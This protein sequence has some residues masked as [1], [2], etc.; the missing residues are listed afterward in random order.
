MELPLQELPC[1]T[2]VTKTSPAQGSTSTVPA[3]Y[4]AALQA[5]LKAEAALAR[6]D[7]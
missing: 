5:A 4:H 7:Y 3:S 1:C 6:L 2:L